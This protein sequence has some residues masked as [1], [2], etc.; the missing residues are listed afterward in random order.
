MV[1]KTMATMV[2]KMMFDMQ[3]IA[4]GGPMELLQKT[5]GASRNEQFN[6]KN[7]SCR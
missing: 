3:T 6:S 7:M 2:A 5:I 4:T 1:G